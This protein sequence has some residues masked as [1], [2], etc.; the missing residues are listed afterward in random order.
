MYRRN[1]KSNTR[2]GFS[3]VELLV[4]LFIVGLIVSV[5]TVS[6]RKIRTDSRDSQRMRDLTTLQT[7]IESFYD[8]NG[9]Y[10]FCTGEITASY[11]NNTDTVG[12]NTNNSCICTNSEKKALSSYHSDFS[13]LGTLLSPVYI[14]VI[15]KDPKDS[16]DYSFVYMRGYRK[17]AGASVTKTDLTS[18][19]ILAGNREGISC[20]TAPCVVISAFGVNWSFNTVI[21]N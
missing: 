12:V 20:T 5:I 10:P 1:K 18:D 19:Y 13:S 7:A 2:R 15:P 14:P 11:C 16:G 6:F 21:G 3:V 17:V 8:T 4:V 9:Y